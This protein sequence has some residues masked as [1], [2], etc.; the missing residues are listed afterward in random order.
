M[1]QHRVRHKVHQAKNFDAGRVIMGAE[2]SDITINY[3]QELLKIQ[4]Q[5]LNGLH[6]TLLQERKVELSEAQVKN[7]LQIIHCSKR[8]HWIVA[9]TVNCK[10]EEVRVYDSL[11]S[12]IDKQTRNI[13]QNLCQATS[14]KGLTSSLFDVKSKLEEKNVGCLALRLHPQLLLV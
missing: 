11:F 12:N 10:L 4:F 3:T 1:T 6:A 5:Q 13:I 8:H 9:S 7:K 14:C 2:L